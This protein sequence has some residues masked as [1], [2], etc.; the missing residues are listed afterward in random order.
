M[1]KFHELKMGDIVLAEYEGQRSEGEVIEL[2]REDKEVCVQTSVQ[3]FWYLPEHL[4]AIPLDDEQLKKFG[5]E[6]QGLADGTVKYLRGPFRILLSAKGDFSHFEMWYR[7]D[8]R[9]IVEPISVH[10]LQNHYH[11]MTKVHLTR[12]SGVQAG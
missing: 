6:Q 1:I 10:E 3:D 4:Y 9:H 7:E 11:Q 12:S 5:F 8:R 2:N